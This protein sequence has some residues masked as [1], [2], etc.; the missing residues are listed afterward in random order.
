MSNQKA[1]SVQ[2]KAKSLASFDRLTSKSAQALIRAFFY[3]PIFMVGCAEASSDAPTLLL[4]TVNSVHPAALLFDSNGGSS[5]NLQEDFT[6]PNHA[7]VTPE[8][9]VTT[10]SIIQ[11][12]T[13]NGTTSHIALVCDLLSLPQAQDVLALV[14][15]SSAYIGTCTEHYYHDQAAYQQ[16][17]A[18]LGRVH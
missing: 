8:F 6:M 12:I 17:L 3:G 1:Y 18:Q 7:Q 11:P 2:V 10:Y 9:D 13:S 16:R 5:R 4:G 15:D 14:G